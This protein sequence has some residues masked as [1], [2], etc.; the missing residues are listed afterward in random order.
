MDIP[1]KTDF[2]P[3]AETLE[4][5]LAARKPVFKVGGVD[6]PGFFSDTGNSSDYFWVI[7]AFFGEFVGFATILYG[8]TSAGGQFAAL[9]IL[10]ALMII[11][12][13]GF[14]AKRLHRNK[15]NN[16]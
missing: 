12:G 8:G 16:V 13:D 9:S 11:V 10:G 3:S 6:M 7:V 2:Q 14:C 5:W 1:N 15:K 4:K